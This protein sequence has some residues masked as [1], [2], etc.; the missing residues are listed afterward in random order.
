MRKLT[1]LDEGLLQRLNLDN[2]L[3]VSELRILLRSLKC[4]EIQ[5]QDALGRLRREKVVR[6][7]QR[8]GGTVEWLLIEYKSTQ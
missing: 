5:I 8:N 2:G 7:Q 6:F 3:T 4:S 1:K